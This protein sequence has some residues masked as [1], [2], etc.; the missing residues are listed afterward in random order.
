MMSFTFFTRGSFEIANFTLLRIFNLYCL[1][2]FLIDFGDLKHF[3][4]GLE[5]PQNPSNSLMGE[6]DI[7]TFPQRP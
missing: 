5:T 6:I 3:E 1:I 7:K 4:Q 2:N